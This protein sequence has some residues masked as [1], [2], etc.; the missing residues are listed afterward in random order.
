MPKNVLVAMD[1]SARAMEAVDFVA[2]SLSTACRV[3]LFAVMRPA[4]LLCEMDTGALKGYLAAHHPDYC[5][6][7]DAQK[8]ALLTAALDAG[9]KRLLEAGF[10]PERVATRLKRMETDIALDIVA[11]SRNGYD[12]LVLG[13]RGLSTVKG[14]FL[15]SVSQKVFN[16]AKEISILVVQ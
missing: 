12:L 3:T 6:E 9:R 15:G 2:R 4:D 5:R 10:A 14:F 1:E 16:H 13:R 11:E 7:V 8:E